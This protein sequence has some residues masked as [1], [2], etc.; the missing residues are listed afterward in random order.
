MAGF[1]C[2]FNDQ[3][4]EHT[5]IESGDNDY[6]GYYGDD[7]VSYTGFTEDLYFTATASSGCTFKC[8]VYRTGSDESSANT[9]AVRATTKNPF[10]YTGDEF[11]VIRA[12]SNEHGT[13]DGEYDEDISGGGGDEEL[14]VVLDVWSDDPSPGYIYFE[15]DNLSA[16][17]T[18]ANYYCAGLSTVDILP[19]D[20]YL[21]PEYDLGC[22]IATSSVPMAEY[23]Y[24]AMGTLQ[25]PPGTYLV[26]G[27][28]RSTDIDNRRYWPAG[29]PAEVTITE[30]GALIPWDWNA[31]RKTIA[32][33]EAVTNHGPIEDFSYDIWNNLVTRI[34]EARSFAGVGMWDMA[35]GTYLSY[36]DTLMYSRDKEL[37]AKRFNSMKYNLG[38]EYSTGI[39]D[40][41]PG[42]PVKGAY[43]TT[44]AEK[45]NEWIEILL[46]AT[47]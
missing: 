24:C 11:I 13:Y 3:G 36:D 20:T 10:I 35:D 34:M 29:D 9:A 14:G 44:I 7:K 41:S 6:I 17:F 4:I 26:Y 12:E 46:S 30:A 27:Y 19:G 33:Y 42:D 16:K 15:M 21:A 25:A 37:T 2:Y 32:A 38:S 8:W 28:V 31:S 40:V 22:I 1:A 5:L 45:L 47:E 18:S 23:P 43:F 39:K